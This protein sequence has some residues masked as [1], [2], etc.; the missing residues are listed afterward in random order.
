[1]TKTKKTPAKK[2]ESLR[3]LRKKLLTQ[4]NTLYRKARVA[5]SS[6]S[7][8]AYAE[9]NE[10][11]RKLRETRESKIDKANKVA[12]PFNTKAGKLLEEAEKVRKE[13]ILIEHE[14]DIIKPGKLIVYKKVY[15]TIR[16]SYYGSILLGQPCVA[17]MEIPAKAKRF[18]DGG[19]DGWK[20]RASE[21]KV[22]SIVGIRDKKSYKTA[23]SA[24]DRSFVYT[25]GKT[26]GPK[27]RFSKSKNTC[28]SGIHFFM[29][30]HRAVAY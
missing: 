24:H 22:L 4:S 21:A 18:Q 23:I 6:V 16:D 12:K 27:G 14:K 26:V 20:C 5:V 29:Q 25:V 7:S 3:A 10:A 1:M 11:E 2:L 8:K 17:T 13:I 15:Q 30:R 9:Y 19:T 28:A